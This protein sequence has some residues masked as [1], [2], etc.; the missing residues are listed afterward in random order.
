MT[1]DIFI[2]TLTRDFRSGKK[3]ILENEITYKFTYKFTQVFKIHKLYLYGY[4][5]LTFISTQKVLRFPAT[6]DL[7]LIFEDLVFESS[8]IVPGP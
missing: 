8:K 6:L 4:H 5:H 2:S 3:L 7:S 1:V